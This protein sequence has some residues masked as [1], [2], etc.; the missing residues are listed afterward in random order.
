[1][2]FSA[3]VFYVFRESAPVLTIAE[4]FLEGE[5]CCIC[6]Q[7]WLPIGSW[8]GPVGIRRC[9]RGHGSE[10]LLAYLSPC[11]AWAMLQCNW[12]NEDVCMQQVGRTRAR[13]GK[14]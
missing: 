8:L 14:R 2:S 5:G 4:A 1:M 3:H 11:W 10:M 13:L 7:L 9:C 12:P 6:R